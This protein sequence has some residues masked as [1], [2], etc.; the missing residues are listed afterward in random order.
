MRGGSRELCAEEETNMFFHPFPLSMNHQMESQET[1][2][3]DEILLIG[4]NR[5]KEKSYPL[6]RFNLSR[7]KE[8]KKN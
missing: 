3:A 2:K 7:R 8:Q 1:T 5:I 4:K 6:D